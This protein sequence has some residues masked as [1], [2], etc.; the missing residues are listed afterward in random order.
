MKKM[1]KVLIVLTL[2][3]GFLGVAYAQFAK[4]ED[5][6]QYR[7][8]VMFL[9][10]QH[11]GRMAAVVKGQSP[12]DKAV[13]EQNAALVE[14]LATLPWEA[15]MVPGTDKGKTGLKSSAFKEKDKFMQDA[16]K[17]EAE[18]AKLAA[19]A[20]TGNMDAI[21]AQLGE[22]AKSCKSCHDDFRK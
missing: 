11:F 7:Q 13:F 4:P 18:T 12:Y 10:G 17:M 6:I 14:T 19:T 8:S 5:A 15:F 22:T 2:I 9:I 21:K 1:A 20:Q 3:L 16:K